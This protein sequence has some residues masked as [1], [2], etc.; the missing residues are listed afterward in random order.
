[1]ATVELTKDNL[2]A[3]S[4][5]QRHRA[6][7]LLGRPGAG[8]A[9]M[10]A[11]DVRAGRR[12]APR[13][14]VRQGRHRGPAGARRRV[15]HHVDPDADDLPR[16][17]RSCSPSPARCP[18]PR[19]RTSSSRYAPSTWRPCTRPSPKRTD[20]TLTRR[21]YP[22]AAIGSSLREDHPRRMAEHVPDAEPAAEPDHTTWRLR[23]TD[24]ARLAG[25]CLAGTAAPLRG[26]AGRRLGAWNLAPRS[27]VTRV[28]D[29]GAGSR[30]GS[31]CS[32]CR[33][34]CSSS[35]SRAS[36]RTSSAARM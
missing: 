9:G 30:S 4:H 28:A 20:A 29:R 18:A 26:P 31:S 34:S 32:S 17:R 3:D 13:P 12:A 27:G 19:S 36:R 35:G 10:F 6:R 1:M 14:R 25:E 24:T 16:E 5:G 21:A 11:P 22:P 23:L 2:R 33:S 15:R 7:R 8:P